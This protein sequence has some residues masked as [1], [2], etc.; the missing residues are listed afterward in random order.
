MASIK[1]NFGNDGNIVSYRVRVC[2]GRDAADKQIWRTRTFPRPEGLTPKREQKEIERQ[3]AEWEHAERE[4][5][6]QGFSAEKDKITFADFVNKHWMP[7]HVQNGKHSAN[8]REFFEYTSG[9]ILEHFGDKIKLKEVNPEAIKRF[10]R[11]LRV[12]KEYSE[13]TQQHVLHTLANVL[14]YAVRTSYLAQNPTDRL[15]AADKPSVV[16][17]AVDFLDADEARA[18]LDA[19]KA[20]PLNWQAYYHLLLFGGL[21][22]G[23]ALG[24]RWGDYDAQCKTMLIARSI[25]AD[26]RAENKI[27]IRTT[28]TGRS[29]TIPVADGVAALLDAWRVEVTGRYQHIEDDWYIFGKDGAPDQP[30]YPTTPALHLR[31]LL[32]RHGLRDVSCHDLRHSAASLGLEAGATLKQISELLGHSNINITSRYYVGLTSQRQRQTV[33]GIEVLINR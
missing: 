25:S 7:D 2:V 31:R 33:N 5:F 8:G 10:L 19:L 4:N 12:D 21:R 6:Q 20:E 15:T 30:L 3:A 24:V 1:T 29:R 14:N 28:K 9:L 32:K 18:F 11:W 13:A 23:E 27:S 26:K 22:R 17:K 16:A